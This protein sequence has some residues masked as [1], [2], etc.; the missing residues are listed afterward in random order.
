[1][2][3]VV[4]A[5]YIQFTQGV[6]VDDIAHFSLGRTAPVDMQEQRHGTLFHQE[7]GGH[8]SASL[9]VWTV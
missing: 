4:A 8:T 2:S 9:P 3:A 7:N 1:M 6:V 5:G